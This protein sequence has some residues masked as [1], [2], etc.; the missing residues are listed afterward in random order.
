MITAAEKRQVLLEEWLRKQAEDDFRVKQSRKATR[1]TMR[2]REEMYADE[3][4][5]NESDD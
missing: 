2:L 3:S 5:R 4:N 1:K